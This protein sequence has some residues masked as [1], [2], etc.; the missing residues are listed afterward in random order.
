MDF[1]VELP[2]GFDV[3]MDSSLLSSEEGL[4]EWTAAVNEALK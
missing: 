4:L 1:G 3:E 2:K